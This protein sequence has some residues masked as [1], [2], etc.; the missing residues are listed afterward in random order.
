MAEVLQNQLGFP[1][2][3]Q[4]GE[5]RTDIVQAVRLG[6]RDKVSVGDY[7][8]KAIT[9]ALKILQ[10]ISF[11]ESVQKKSPVGAY[12][13]PVPGAFVSLIFEPSLCKST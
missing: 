5:H 10:L 12:I 4:P 3:P 11:C 8:R 2:N 6:S 7:Y 1:C 9:Y 13:K